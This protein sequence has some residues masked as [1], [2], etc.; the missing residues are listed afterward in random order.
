[1]ELDLS[2]WVKEARGI[3]AQSI[4]ISPDEV[5]ID[6]SIESFEPWD[7][8]VHVKVMMSVEERLGQPL[9]PVEAV[10]MFDL[11]SIAK[12]LSAA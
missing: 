10:K 9:D 7:S 1:M 2:D 6:A 8:I 3:L 12:Y 4:G 11:A 5:P